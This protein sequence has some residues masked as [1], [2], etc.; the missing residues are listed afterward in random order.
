M[1]ET[2]HEFDLMPE[3]FLEKNLYDYSVISFGSWG[4]GQDQQLLHLKENIKHI[5]PE[6]VIL[7]WIT[8]DLIDNREAIGFLGPKP[9]FKLDGEKLIYPK[10]KMRE[11]TL[12]TLFYN[13]YSYR[14]Y[15]A[16]KHKY[17]FFN[18][19]H[20]YK[21]NYINKCEDSNEYMNFKKLLENYFDNQVYE[22]H[23]FSSENKPKPYDK[24]IIKLAEFELWKRNSVEREYN[25]FL[26]FK[27]KNI[28]KDGDF[29]SW[30]R[31]IYS[32]NELSDIKLT[33]SL[34]KE[35]QKVSIENNAKFIIFFPIIDNKRLLPFKINE[36][37]RICKDGNEIEYSSRF[38]YERLNLIFKNI[39]NV[40][41]VSHNIKND[42]YD[43]F[44][45]HPTPELNQILMKKLSEYIKSIN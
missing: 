26:K 36:T 30:N 29:F 19:G 1:I 38:A 31:N 5:K 2:S 27:G 8:N 33:N 7:W 10:K 42:W 28:Y 14:L 17:K 16:I 23:R 37:H 11:K 34:L 15:L 13:F 9:T 20:K 3:R 18:R 12:Y 6:I 21:L 44:D 40:Y 22:L 24:K 45:G 39:K 41:I 4:W 25:K 35:I 43:A 32:S